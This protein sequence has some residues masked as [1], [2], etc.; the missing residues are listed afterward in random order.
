MA[1]A[2]SKTVAILV[3]NHGALGDTGNK[4]GYYLPEVRRNAFL[5]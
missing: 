3:T 4:T 2:S 5:T 1:G